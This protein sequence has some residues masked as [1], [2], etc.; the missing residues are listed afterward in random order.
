M[1]LDKF[2]VIC[3]LAVGA[4]SCALQ[5]ESKEQIA[6]DK[7]LDKAYSAGL[8]T[9]QEYNAKKAAF[10][11]RA[12]AVAA[13]DKALAS[14]VLTHDEYAAKK[15]ALLEQAPPPVPETTPASNA[16]TAAPQPALPGHTYQMKLIQIMDSQGFEKPVPSA[17][18]LIPTGWQFQGGTTWNIKDTCNTIRTAFQASGPDGRA[19]EVFP[20]YNWTWADD[21]TYMRQAAAQMAQFGSHSCDVQPPINATEYLKRN[22]GKIR[23]NVAI[24]AIEPAPKLLQNFQDQARQAEQMAAQFHLQQKVTPDVVRARLK[25]DLNGRPV[26]EWIFAATVITATRGPS[27][28]SRTLQ[29][30]QANSYNCLGVMTAVRTPAGQLD[31]NEQFFELLNSTYHVNPDWQKRVTANAQ[32]MQQIEL[33]GARDRSAIISKNA[34]D[35]RNIQQRSFENQQ[36][37]EDQN[38]RAFDQVIR[39]VESYRNPST[40]DTVELDSSYGHAWVRGDGTYLLTDQAGYNPNS[41][42]QGNWTQLEH[43]KP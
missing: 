25:Y 7:A 3:V 39:G 20:T 30:V 14:G 29:M 5:Q 15:A 23:P 32:A 37:A 19:F 8:L 41:N 2:V 34:E 36:R 9:R 42:L 38:F 18:M 6:F 17:S 10:A 12:D 24:A 21:P 43:V 31:A 13:L 26:E 33:K 22:I 11:K 16:S 40:G 35:I 27:F 4:A 1:A 28:N